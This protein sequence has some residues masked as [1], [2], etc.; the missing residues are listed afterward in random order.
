MLAQQLFLNYH[1][2]ME[3][4]RLVSAGE[5][6]FDG[7]SNEM[8]QKL[9]VVSEAEAR[10]AELLTQR[11]E[12][13]RAAQAPFMQPLRA[14]AEALQAAQTEAS[15]EQLLKQL[16]ELAIDE[17]ER[18]AFSLI[19][20][21]SGVSPEN[22]AKQYVDALKGD[23]LSR[24][25]TEPTL[26]KINGFAA[27][28]RT[29]LEFNTTVPVLAVRIGWQAVYDA[30]AEFEGKP[31]RT[32]EYEKECSLIFG[33]VAKEDVIIECAES[34]SAFGQSGEPVGV[35][36][37]FKE[38][39]KSLVSQQECGRVESELKETTQCKLVLVSSRDVEFE[40]PL[41]F[42]DSPVDWSAGPEFDFSM[43]EDHPLNPREKLTR[44]ART[45]IAYGVQINSVLQQLAADEHIP[46]TTKRTLFDFKRENSL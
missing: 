16:R 23:E 12:A 38:A 39:G 36:L 29:L 17:T 18:D 28:Y 10:V 34:N 35:R 24:D 11:D 46:E 37:H 4:S 41:G 22:F 25:W 26:Q 31:A 43:V 6:I 5:T 13:V 7:I 30:Q 44:D 20:K 19:L 8:S 45:F 14:A 2:P 42:Y 27:F 3:T 32:G 33:N 9:A 1:E 40:Q 21:R 15:T